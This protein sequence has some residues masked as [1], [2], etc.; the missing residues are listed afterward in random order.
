MKYTNKYKLPDAYVRAAINDRYSRGESDF[1]PTSLAQ[2]P[3]ATALLKEF[4][5]DVVV[6][7]SSRVAAIIGQGAHSIAERAAREGIDLCEKRFFA[8]FIVDGKPY[9]ISAQVDLY[10]TD[11]GHLIDWKTTKAYA[12]SKRA[13][14]GKKPEWIAQLNIG[15]EILRRNGHN[16][17]RLS[18]IALLK[19]FRD[20]DAGRNGMPESEVMQV[21]I[22]FW[23][24]GETIAYIEHRVRLHAQATIHTVCDTKENWSG[25]RCGKWCDASSVCDQ[26]KQSLKSGLIMPKTK[27]VNI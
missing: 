4:Y 22:P 2:P 21:D 14:F 16:P 26:Y 27:E 15:A 1:S 23:S 24:E 9:I 11:T 25:R 17:K 7:V 20:D 8:E 19:D 3:R 10:E 6:D 5:N 12:F 13:G 18:I